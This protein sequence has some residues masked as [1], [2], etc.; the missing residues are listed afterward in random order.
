MSDVVISQ[1][2][3]NEFSVYLEAG[4][5][6]MRRIVATSIFSQNASIDGYRPFSVKSSWLNKTEPHG[7]WLQATGKSCYDNS[8][9]SVSPIF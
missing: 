4:N 6:A 1:L 8:E 7:E 2:K 9:L 3:S 5:I